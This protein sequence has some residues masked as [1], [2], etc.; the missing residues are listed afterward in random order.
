MSPLQINWEKSK[1]YEHSVRCGVGSRCVLLVASWTFWFVVWGTSPV[2]LNATSLHRHALFGFQFALSVGFLPGSL[3]SKWGESNG[4]SDTAVSKQCVSSCAKKQREAC[5]FQQKQNMVRPCSSRSK[6]RGSIQKSSNFCGWQLCLWCVVTCIRVGEATNP[7][8]VFMPKC[9]ENL[10]ILDSNSWSCGVF[11]PSGANARV[12]ILAN[13]PGQ[14][15]FG[16]ET[17]L[18]NHGVSKVRKG[19]KALASKYKYFVPGF[20]CEH[21]SDSGVG[22]FSGVC[23]MS[24]FPCRPLPNSFEPELYRTARLQVVGLQIKNLWIQAGV[25]YGFP[26][27]YTHHQPQHQTEIL[28]DALVTRVACESTGP[29]LVCGD[30]NHDANVLA[31]IQKLRALGFREAQEIAM[32]R[33]GLPEQPTGLGQLK[34][35]QMWLSR[36]LQQLLVAVSVHHDFWPTHASVVCHFDHDGT[37]L[38]CDRWHVPTAFP[39][40]SDWNSDIQ[41]SSGGAIE[42]YAAFWWQVE[43]QA[44]N[45]LAQ[46]GIVVTKRQKGRAHTLQSKPVLTQIAPTKKGRTGDLQP[47]F[48]GISRL[49][50]QWFRQLRRFDALI[51]IQQKPTHRLQSLALWRSITHAAGFRGGFHN[52]WQAQQGVPCWKQCFPIV[53]PPFE[54]VSLAFAFFHQEVR[55]FEVTLGKQRLRYAK[56]RR[57]NELNLVFQDCHDEPSQPLDVL[58]RSTE[59]AIETIENDESITLT[60]PAKLDDALPLVANGQPYHIIISSHDQVWLENT[61]DL[62]PGDVLRQE[63]VVG[64]DRRIL[65]CFEEIWKPRWQKMSHLHESQWNQVLDFIDQVLPPVK[66]NIPQWTTEQFRHIVASKKKRAATGPDGV[67]R[68]DLLALPSQACDMLANMMN[69]FE[70]QAQWPKQMATGFITSLDKRKGDGWVDSYRPITV[71]SLLY[72]A[73]STHKAKC[74]LKSL[75]DIMPASVRGGIPAR[76]AKSVWYEVAQLVE[77]AQVTDSQLHGLAIDIR[78]AFNSIPRLPIWAALMRMNFPIPILRAWC[79]FVSAQCRHFT[80]R[81]SVGSPIDSNVGFPEGC[82]LSVFSMSILDWMLE[83]WIGA[84]Q[85]GPCKLFAYVDDWQWV[86]PSIEQYSKLWQTLD[87]FTK[88]WTIEIDIQKSFAWALDR[89]GRKA[90]AGHGIKVV[91]AAKDLGAHQNFSK[92]TGNCELQ[93]RLGVMPNVWKKLGLSHAPYK[94]KIVALYQLGWPK[95]LHGISITNLGASHFVKLR[96]GAMK[97]IN[98]TKVG[99]NPSLHLCLYNPMADP[100]FFAIIQ[101]I[102]ESRELGQIEQ[103][104]SMLQLVAVEAPEVPKNGPSFLLA[105]RLSRLGWSLQTNGTFHDQF[106]TVDVFAMHPDALFQRVKWSWP[107]VLQCEVAHRPSFGG[108]QNAD[109]DELSKVLATFGSADQA[110]LRSSM[111]GTMFLDIHKEKVERGKQSKCV[112]CN[113]GDS[114]HH[115]VWQCPV[116]QQA[117]DSFPWP[118]MVPHLPPC[119]SN[120]AWPVTPPSWKAYL[121]MLEELPEFPADPVRLPQVAELDLFTDGSCMFPRDAKF[122]VAAWAITAACPTSGL[123]DH[124]V[125]QCGHVTGQHQTA[126]RAELLAVLEAI[127]LAIRVQKRTRIWS[128]CLSVL[129]KVKKLFL[130]GTIKLNSSH[131]DLWQQVADLCEQGAGDLVTLHK[132][133]S[134]CSGALAETELERWAFWHNKLVDE[135]ASKW[136]MSRPQWFWDQWQQMVLDVQTCRRVHAE[137]LK[138]HLAVGRLGDKLI[139]TRITCQKISI[140]RKRGRRNC[141]EGWESRTGNPYP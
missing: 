17:H 24:T 30:F 116:F 131:S 119:L 77:L 83:L 88:A 114:F 104:R 3:L 14:V 80:V 95:A 107:L 120:H 141:A 40:P 93:K 89:D 50:A 51:K 92:R 115:R 100:E 84:S 10:Q 82:A 60:A 25:A 41:P 38:I 19:L 32:T 137:I 58:V 63:V 78:R 18:T 29:R 108:L 101:T 15:W 106:G 97:G 71:F 90:M 136:N 62:Q 23:A 9:D 121:K 129:N 122:R 12:D 124:E 33:W 76:Q 69:Q 11:N 16:S 127:R 98:A 1:G 48:V 102:R 87:E 49:H 52:W 54:E 26:T 53:L 45:C 42:Q 75:G 110:Y 135:A 112:F 7:G 79:A 74:A 91:Y 73:W 57:L 140:P 123:L 31:P 96:T 36:E 20:P 132:V 103:L 99:A 6:N 118:E 21:R 113:Q 109:L 22:N 47:N 37:P 126:Y 35:D 72:R 139:P 46:K 65:Q 4:F 128:D 130:G 105:K 111:D 67:S 27:G 13:L 39:W 5:G 85:V 55:E 2:V 125:V 86:F 56:Q 117:R 134:H 34:L 28:L 8:P 138:V 59:V 61:S 94:H 81:Q 66:W 64:T 44:S 68:K 133:V 70:D 43:Q